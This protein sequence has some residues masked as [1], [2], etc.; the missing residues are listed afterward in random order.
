MGLGAAPGILLRSFNNSGSYRVHFNISSS[1]QQITFVH[2]KRC[3]A[4][5]PKVSTPLLP[6]VDSASIAAVCFS[7]RTGQSFFGFRYGN[8]VNVIWHQA[9]CPD[10]NSVFAAPFG[11]QVKIGY[12]IVVTEKGLLSTVAALGDV[13]GYARGYN[14]CNSCH[15]WTIAETG[16][17]S[18]KYTVP[19]TLCGAQK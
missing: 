17:L 2:R 3:K 1:C 14:S 11:H 19:R 15:G 6:K 9:P 16:S 12:V 8:Q 7:D 4:F 13:V 10:L 5:L 18:I